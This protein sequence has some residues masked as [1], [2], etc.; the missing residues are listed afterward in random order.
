[1]TI[2]PS[3]SLGRRLLATVT[4]MVF[5]AAAC[6]DEGE[7]SAPVD[8]EPTPTTADGGAPEPDDDELV[9]GVGG[10]TL[11]LSECPSGWNPTEGITDTEIRFGTSRPESGPLAVLSLLTRGIQAYFSYVNGAHGGVDGRQLVLIE[12]DDAYE[13]SRTVT[14]VVELVERE[15]VFGLVGV[16]GTPNNL[17]VRDDVNAWCIPHLFNTTGAPEWGEVDDYPWTTGAILPYPAE[18]AVWAD[19]IEELFPDGATVAVLSFDN[20]FGLSYERA[21][22]TAIAGTSIEVISRQHHEATAPN[23]RDQVTTMA[24]SRADVV[25]G[26]TTGTFCPML[27]ETIEQSAWEPTVIISATCASPQATFVPIAPA[28][29]GVLVAASQKPLLA[30]STDAGVVE[31]AQL[32]EEWAP[33][34]PATIGIIAVGWQIGEMLHLSLLAAMEMEGGINR[35][36]VLLG[37]RSLDFQSSLNLEGVAIRMVG[38]EDPYPLEAAR[39][40]AWRV[41]EGQY[42]AVSEVY[43]YEGRTGSLG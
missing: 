35:Q 15:Q 39:M 26:M 5:L 30:D 40:Q 33:G 31:Y 24:A 28:G 17:A 22:D 29:D 4:A 42:E 36:N 7:S 16:V 41:A 25:L 21:F 14:N 11:D 38:A 19:Y 20:D 13:P 8:N 10:F 3:I 12:R 6:G 37:A 1:M 9:R 27:I 32:L 43:D 2:Y 18:A 23:L 34:T